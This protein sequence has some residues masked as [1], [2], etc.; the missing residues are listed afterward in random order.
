MVCSGQ[1]GYL[2][3]V[4]LL[5]ALFGLFAAISSFRFISTTRCFRIRQMYSAIICACY[6]I[7]AFFLLLLKSTTENKIKMKQ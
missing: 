7:V 3:T 5:Q 6:Q 4:F 1:S 2:D